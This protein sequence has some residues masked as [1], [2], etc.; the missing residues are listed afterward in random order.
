M[1]VIV[2]SIQ[3][4]NEKTVIYGIT[5]IEIIKGIWKCEESPVLLNAYSVEL[6]FGEF[7]KQIATEPQEEIYAEIWS[8]DNTVHFHGIC[9]DI[10]DDVYYIRFQHDWLDMV[11]IPEN[12]TNKI[13]KGDYV[14]FSAKYWNVWIY[15]Y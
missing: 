12:T 5:E 7:D 4:D 14:S 15:P 11:E 2:S 13:N 6:S 1:R 8:I 9:E 10:D 3:S